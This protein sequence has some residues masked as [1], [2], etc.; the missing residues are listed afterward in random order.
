MKRIWIKQWAWLVA[1]GLILVIVGAAIV[2]S[3]HAKVAA[4]P[5][6]SASPTATPTAQDTAVHAGPGQDNAGG[7]SAPIQTPLSNPD[8]P[9][10]STLA[11]PIGPENNV[12]SVSLAGTTA[13]ESTCRSVAGAS[14]RI[15]AT[16]GTTTITVGPTK[17][18]SGGAS[19]GAVFDWNANK[20]TT[21]T[22]SIVAVATKDAQTVK[23]DPQT[24]EVTK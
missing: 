24:L 11:K 1:V 21:G 5:R 6:A 17:S 16:M 18:I 12:S 19:D 7:S 9:V 2:L 20:L 15:D 8:H 14:C 13:M 23:S 4:L 22:W 10:T 3:R